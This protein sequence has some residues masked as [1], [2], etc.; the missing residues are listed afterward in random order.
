MLKYLFTNATNDRR[1]RQF[2]RSY[3]GFEISFFKFY[4]PPFFK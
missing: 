2:N 1:D 3:I 4:A